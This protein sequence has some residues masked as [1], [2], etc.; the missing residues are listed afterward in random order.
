MKS[1]WPICSI[2]LN[3]TMFKPTSVIFRLISI[4]FFGYIVYN[5]FSDEKK[6]EDLKDFTIK[7]VTDLFD[8]SKE[9][10]IGKLALGGGAQNK[11]SFKHKYK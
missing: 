5:F 3:D 10:E 6:V 1:L 8:Y 9:W 2:E 4:S 7:G 11:K